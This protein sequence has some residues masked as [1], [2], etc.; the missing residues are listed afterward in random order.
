MSV[1]VS[2]ER[3]IGS[4]LFIGTLL[5]M[6]IVLI[7]GILYLMQHGSD[8]L[9]LQLLRSA[10]IPR[11]TNEILLTAISL[12]PL[13]IVQLGLLLLVGTQVLRVLLLFL[14]YFKSGDVWFSLF[15]GAILLV[16]IYSFS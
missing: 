5:P 14:F 11:T 13:G 3:K 8:T 6:L 2:I 10:P 16:L 9:Q 1:V 7:G 4:V 12:T 15:C